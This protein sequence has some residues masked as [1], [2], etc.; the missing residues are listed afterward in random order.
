MYRLNTRQTI[1]GREADCDPK[2]SWIATDQR[3]RSPNIH[4]ITEDSHDVVSR[5]GE[6][7]STPG[8]GEGLV[9]RRS[10]DSIETTHQLQRQFRTDTRQATLSHW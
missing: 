9:V 2:T 8:S 10:P 5:E 6:E 1:R 3:S 7:G 4:T